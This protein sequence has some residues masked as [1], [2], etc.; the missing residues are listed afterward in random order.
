MR[1]VNTNGGHAIGVHNGD[2]SKVQKLLRDGRIRYYA[3]A[4][5]REDSQLDKLVK[6]IIDRTVT[7]EKL[8]NFH[9][10]CKK[11]GNG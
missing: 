4:D 5:Y 7:N 6:G 8:E 3:N 1:L 10:A 9:Y 2:P 11:D